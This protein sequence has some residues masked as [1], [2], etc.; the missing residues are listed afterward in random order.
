MKKIVSIIAVMAIALVSIS[1]CLDGEGA[2]ATINYYAICDTIEY[3]DTTNARFDKLIKS[4]FV[5]VFQESADVEESM[6]IYAEAKCND[7]AIA[8]WRKMYSTYSL[9]S[10]ASKMFKEHNDTLSKHMGIENVAQLEKELKPMILK[11]KL[12]NVQGAI[13]YKNDL[14]LK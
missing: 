4:S 9:S 6:S 8:T 11:T 5:T 1:S 10:I 14:Y 13:V 2:S 3:T 12:Y 7:Q